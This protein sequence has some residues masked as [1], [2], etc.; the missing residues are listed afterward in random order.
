MPLR[1]L[2]SLFPLSNIVSAQTDSLSVKQ[3][4][5]IFTFEQSPEFP[6]GNQV[7][8]SIIYEHLEYPQ[9]EKDNHI[10][11]VV[12]VRFIVNEDGSVSDATITKKVSY[13][14]DK[15][16][17]RVVKLLP[18]FIPGRHQG[19]A[20]KVNCQL[21]IRFELSD[22]SKAPYPQGVIQQPRK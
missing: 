4:A 2:L 20:V 15:E 10:Q 3:Q 11:G 18:A 22:K 12:G 7:L 21:P 19:K 6:G 16:A 13:G 1:F 8:M 14:L 5:G 9:M 17:L